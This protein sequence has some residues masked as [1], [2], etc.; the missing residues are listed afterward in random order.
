MSMLQTIRDRAQGIMAWVL[1]IVVGVPFILWGIQNY[2]DVGKEKPAAKVGG[3][4]IF[5]RDVTRSYERL[6]QEMG[7][8]P[9]LDEK[10][11]RKQAMEQLISEE[12][13]SQSADAAGLAVSDQQAREL[14]QSLPYFQVDGHFDKEKYKASLAAQRL[15]PAQFA[16]RIKGSLLNQQFQ[17]ALLASGFATKNE[18][19]N[20]M[21][22][23]NQERLVRYIKLA[24]KPVSRGFGDEEL[25]A[26]YAAHIADF[27]TPEKVAVDFLMLSLDEIAAKTEVSEEEVRKLYE[28]QKSNYGTAERRK[29][30]HILVT[31]DQADPNSDA[32]ALAKAVAIR[33]RLTKGED[34][35]A[36]AKELSDDQVSSKSGGDLGYLNRDALDPALSNEAEKLAAGEVSSPVKTSFGYH[37]IKL[38]EWIPASYKPFEKV[39]E[40]VR[41]QAQKNKAESS[42]YERGQKLAELTFEHPDT[43]EVAASE[44]GLKI[45]STGLFTR[46]QG[47]GL[48]DEENV[49]KTAFSEDVIAGKNSEP[50]E[51]D[52]EKAVVLRVRDHESSSDKP[53]EQVR[54]EIEA[55]LRKQ[56]ALDLL[57]R[58]VDE[59][60]SGMKNGKALGEIAKEQG[61]DIRE[62]KLKR[63]SEDTPFSLLKAV[64]ETARPEP[65]KPVPGNVPDTDG[66]RFVFSVVSVKDGETD[67]KDPKEQESTT[68][69][70][71][72]G[73]GQ[74]EFQA[75]V[76]RLRELKDV[77]VLKTD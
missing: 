31:V 59:M 54:P 26:Y 60:V 51:I 70:L 33:D 75:F 44:L 57:S 17:Q 66:S 25:R 10:A 9:D 73:Y 36:L 20:L 61:L 32:T 5:D 8:S 13:I 71:E 1:L 74:L 58:Q 29:I 12:V 30:S 72:R 23:K 4:E 14:I 19:E 69:Y 41:T 16:A 15:T 68:E 3:H 52:E 46:G 28:E 34:F 49:R 11:L 39:R 76:D 55:I 56:E 38:T 27:R 22:L 7:A 50:V 24:P 18:V 35:A 42:F 48:A 45:Q 64:F 40:E 63:T 21:R 43:L 67:I 65:E 2:I 37:L 6:I 77:E 53:F 47:D 62:A